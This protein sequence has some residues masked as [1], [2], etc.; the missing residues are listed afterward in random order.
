MAI[1]HHAYGFAP[2][3]YLSALYSASVVGGAADPDALRSH[4]AAIAKSANGE[5]RKILDYLRYDDEW[6]NAEPSGSGVP[7]WLEISLI[8]HLRPLPSLSH[9]EPHS[10]FVLD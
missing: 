8:P 9:H 4:A 7:E 2:E 1:R 3:E 6:W 5:A 10:Y